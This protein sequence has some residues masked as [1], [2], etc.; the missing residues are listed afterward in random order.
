MYFYP[1]AHIQGGS[2]D[3][4]RLPDLVHGSSILQNGMF[5][6]ADST[7]KYQVSFY[8][9]YMR[10]K[11]R[12]TRIGFLDTTCRDT[13]SNGMCGLDMG[14]FPGPARSTPTKSWRNVR[15]LSLSREV[16]WRLGLQIQCRFP[17]AG[18]VLAALWVGHSQT[19][20]PGDNKT[21]Q[22]MFAC[23]FV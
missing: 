7:H 22:G 5:E 16:P 23:R 8:K 20:S 12:M 11:R 6:A 13:V 2:T 9:R 1:A 17:A 18:P 14:F 10:N 4:L 15:V 3:G 19:Y 21:A